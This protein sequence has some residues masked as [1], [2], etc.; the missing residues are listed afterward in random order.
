MA[1]NRNSYTLT[2][3]LGEPLTK[4]EA[5]AYVRTNTDATT[6]QR[7]IQMDV[8][9]R[10]KLLR[11]IMGKN[12]LS[13]TYDEVF[14]YV[15]MPGG[16]TSRLEKFLSAILGE[17]V[18]IEQL[19]PREGTLLY[20]E[21]SFVIADIVVRLKTGSTVNVEIQKIGYMFPGERSSCYTADMIMRQ[22]NYL[23]NSNSNFTYKLMKPVYLIVFME[24][25]PELFHVTKEYIHKKVSNFNTGIQ[26]NLLD[27]IYYIALD[28][29]R[30]L[31]QNIRT[32]QDAWL[33]FLTEDDPDE[34]VHFVND[35]PEFLPCY[36]DLIEFRHNPKEMI[37]LFSEALKKMDRNTERYMVEELNKKVYNLIDQNSELQNTNSKL[38]SCISEKDAIIQ[39]LKQ[40][41]AQNNL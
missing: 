28:T 31:S 9:Y 39:E 22:Y 41:L 12:G 13:I 14:R 6:Y 4:Q 35:F 33:K 36:H 32:E 29:F 15:M 26:L 23:K 10:E 34:I 40:K 11:F 21:G 3:I 38:Q 27:N 37:F 30:S 16:T 1:T 19:L 24:N 25:S 17:S 8:A 20:E 2:D 5:L 7:F 18:T